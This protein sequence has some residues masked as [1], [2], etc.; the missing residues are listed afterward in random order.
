MQ[1]S[2]Y[3][4]RNIV[5]LIVGT[6]FFY[7]CTNKTLKEWDELHDSTKPEIV[8]KNVEIKQ[9]R[10]GIVQ[11]KAF[12]N[13]VIEKQKMDRPYIYICPE[14]LHIWQYDSISQTNFELTADSA[15]IIELEQYYELWGNVRIERK[16]DSTLA[17]TEKLIID[18]KKNTIFTDQKIIINKLN[19]L[20]DVTASGFQ[21][22]LT[23]ENPTFYNITEG[24][25]NYKNIELRKPLQ[26]K[27]TD[28]S[29]NEKNSRK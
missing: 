20:K 14:G 8:G 29:M 24:E 13:K 2:R 12:I 19:Q 9:S 4:F 21:S 15:Y 25:V 5:L 1:T 26:E 27:K 6:V 7:A 18:Q 22:D 23:F 11:F 28:G 3:I 10:S 17:I 16:Q